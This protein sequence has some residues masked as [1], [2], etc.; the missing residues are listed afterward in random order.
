MYCVTIYI[1]AFL[2]NA[3]KMLTQNVK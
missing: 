2:M 3:A 1:S